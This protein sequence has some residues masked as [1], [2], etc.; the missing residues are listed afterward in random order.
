[1][2]NRIQVLASPRYVHLRRRNMNRMHVDHRLIVVRLR[3]T[4]ASLRVRNVW[5]GGQRYAVVPVI[6][7]MNIGFINC[8]A[9]GWVEHV[10]GARLL[11]KIVF[12]VRRVNGGGTVLPATVADHF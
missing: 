5:Q 3:H 4:K 7:S 11:G 1:M 9:H 6:R 10:S 12:L 2:V 8:T